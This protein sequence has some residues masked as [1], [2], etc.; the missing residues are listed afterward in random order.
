MTRICVV[1]GLLFA[2]VAL[3]GCVERKLIIRSDPPGAEVFLNHDAALLATTPA[4][5][6]FTDYGVYAVRLVKADYEE[7]NARAEVDA[8]WWS[9]PPIDLFVEV[10]WPFTVPDHHEFTWELTP[11]SESLAPEALRA[12]QAELIRRAEEFREESKEELREEER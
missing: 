3:S 5:T 1:S 12:R 6:S 8:P 9:Y 7:L 10:L 11:L 2:L 4:E